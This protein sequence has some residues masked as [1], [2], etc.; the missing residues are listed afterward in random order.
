[1]EKATAPQEDRSYQ[2]LCAM[3]D[4]SLVDLSSVPFILNLVLAYMSLMG[5]WSLLILL[6]RKEKKL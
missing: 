4:F 2:V 5:W 3:F 1:M 6:L